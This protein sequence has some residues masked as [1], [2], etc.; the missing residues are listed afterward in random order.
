[1]ES[2]KM[3]LNNRGS[4]PNGIRIL[5]SLAEAVFML[6]K[7]KYSPFEVHKYY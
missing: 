4:T 2:T 5:V 3:E 7:A 6:Q 1:M